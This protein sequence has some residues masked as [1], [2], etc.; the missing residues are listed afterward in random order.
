MILLESSDAGAIKY[1]ESLDVKSI[2]KQFQNG[3]DEVD[4]KAIQLGY[5]LEIQL[6]KK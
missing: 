6:M 2:D 4:F 1:L 5:L 3:K